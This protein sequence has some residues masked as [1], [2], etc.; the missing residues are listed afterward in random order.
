MFSAYLWPLAVANVCTLKTHLTMDGYAHNSNIWCKNTDWIEALYSALFVWA[1]NPI[2][3]VAT[4]RSQRGINPKLSSSEGWL[5]LTNLCNK[6]QVPTYKSVQQGLHC[7]DH[8]R[9][10][11][12]TVLARH[13]SPTLIVCAQQCQD[14]Y[15]YKTHL[16]NCPRP[17][18]T[19]QI[20]IQNTSRQLSL[21]SYL[22]LSESRAFFK[23]LPP[24]FSLSHYKLALSKTKWLALH[25]TQ[26]LERN[27]HVNTKTS[28]RVV[29]TDGFSSNILESPVQ[30]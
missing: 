21:P 18:T 16:D 13:T 11:V 23:F 24:R 19:R 30:L 26:L 1:R 20:Q 4:L 10:D 15:K 5:I 2:P 3:F 14:K 28:R 25:I 27:M 7:L 12:C 17:T 6:Y 9:T 8:G 29:L 22:L